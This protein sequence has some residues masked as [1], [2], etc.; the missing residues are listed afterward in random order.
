MKHSFEKQ[1][2]AVNVARVSFN[3]NSHA[4]NKTEISEALN[5]ALSSLAALNLNP[6]I[7][8]RVKELEESLKAIIGHIENGFLVRDISKDHEPGWAVKQLPFLNDLGK[9]QKLLTTK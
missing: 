3:Q 2:N 1:I 5:D 7:F 8:Q 6:D 4:S 9:A